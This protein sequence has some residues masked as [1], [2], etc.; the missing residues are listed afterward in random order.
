MIEQKT[1]S[2]VNPLR[3]IKIT[4][5]CIIALLVVFGVYWFLPLE[6][7]NY[8]VNGQ[9][10]FSIGYPFRFKNTINKFGDF[11]DIGKTSQDGVNNVVLHFIYD[12]GSNTFNSEPDGTGSEISYDK[13]KSCADLVKYDVYRNTQG[14]ISGYK[15]SQINGR[16]ICYLN[17]DQVMEPENTSGLLIFNPKPI[18]VMSVLYPKYES[19]QAK[20]MLHSIRIYK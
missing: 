12:S 15:S 18:G 2:T 11:L 9:K 10:I 14:Y 3:I 20:L 4:F 13:I 5:L 7:Y 16:T 17:N 8:S 1:K 19:F 6:R